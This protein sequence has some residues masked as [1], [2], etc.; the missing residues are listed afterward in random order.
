MKNYFSFTS[1]LKWFDFCKIN[2]FHPSL[3]ILL[4]IFHSFSIECEEKTVSALYSLFALPPHL[5]SVFLLRGEKKTFVIV[6]FTACTD[7]IK[8]FTQIISSP[9][10]IFGAPELFLSHN[11]MWHISTK[12]FYSATAGM[13]L[14][15]WFHR[16]I[17]QFY[18][19]A[20]YEKRIKLWLSIRCYVLCIDQ[21][22]STVFMCSFSTESS[23]KNEVRLVDGCRGKLLCRN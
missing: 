6:H 5:L 17:G 4:N 19:S 23:R 15:L 2:L 14:F 22:K 18:M 12:Y 8:G 21:T 10:H 7:D 1:R 16:L 11:F 20:L 13:F 3:F 9:P